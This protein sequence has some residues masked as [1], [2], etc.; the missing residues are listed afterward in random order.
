MYDDEWANILAQT[1]CWLPLTMECRCLIDFCFS[2][3]ALDMWQT[4]Q[5][6]QYHY[7]YYIAKTSHFGH[8]QKEVGAPRDG[9][10]D[11]YCW[12][13]ALLICI[14]YLMLGPF[15]WLSGFNSDFISYNPIL[16]SDVQLW[17]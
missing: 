8:N 13:Y 15:Y 6:F 11:L 10:P 12:G 1:F 2:G 9:F 3:T 16:K 4:M 7:D 14:L 5:L 17:I